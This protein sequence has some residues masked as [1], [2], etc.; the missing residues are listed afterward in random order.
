[1]RSAALILT[2]FLVCLG[3]TG[4]GS[5]AIP[6]SA[7][8]I[9]GL[10][11]V[12]DESAVIEL[13][14]CGEEW[15]GHIY[16]SHDLANSPPGTLRDGSNP[17]PG[18]RQRPICD[19]QII[20]GLRPESKNFYGGGTVYN[21]DDGLTYGAEVR[22]EANDT[23]RFRGFIALPLLGG[24]QVWRRPDQPPKHCVN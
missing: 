8:T 19:L 15:C 18:L 9:Q 1:M 16:W 11:L 4:P 21:P 22:L 6:G 7:P 2:F 23:L 20:K 14:A 17:N 10:W 12:E 24:S 5:A 13:R 3:A